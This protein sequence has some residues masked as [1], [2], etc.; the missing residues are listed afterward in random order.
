MK[1]ILLIGC[2]AVILFASCSKSPAVSPV[3]PPPVNKD[4]TVLATTT[5][6]LF[7]YTPN[8]NWINDP[9]GLVYFNGSYHLFSQYNPSGFV[10][11]NMN[12]DQAASTDFFS[13]QENGL[14]IKELFN[15][16]GSTAMIFSGST[17]V[18]SLN[19]SGFATQAGQIPLVAV[20]TLNNTAANGG[21][22]P[23]TQGIS[24]SLDNGQTWTAYSK[25]P[26]LDINSTQFRDPKV[27]WY[28]PSSKWI[29]VVSKPDVDSVRIYGST[30]LKKWTYQSDFGAIGNTNQV[31]ECPD[32]FPLTIEGGGAAKWVLTVSA[33]G[34]ENGFGGMQ[35]FIGTFDGT[36]FTADNYNYPLYVDF[37]KDYYAG[38]TFNGM[39]AADGRRVMVAW[40]N[41]WSYAGVIP[42]IGYRGQYSIPR[43]LSLRKVSNSDGY[44]L[45][46]SPVAELGA[47]ETT[48][49]TSASKNLS[50][51]VANLD[52]VSGTSLDIQF[53]LNMG[54]ATSA[55]INVLVS[56]TELTPVTINKTY[57][58]VSLDRTKSGNSS[59][60]GQFA[61]IESAKM[62]NV[63][64]GNITCRILI[65]QSIV[66]VFVN[67]GEYSITD[68]V[69]PT[70]AKGGIQLFSQG[71]AATFTNINVKT[72]SKTTH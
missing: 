5:R 39:P 41:N 46:Q 49:Y 71:G 53:T 15:T 40:A 56:G 52:S 68:L 21:A 54:T 30:N 33:G 42:T 26:V 19:T 2:L 69:F 25:N 61:G 28:A 51:T 43:S 31:W 36:K 67:G 48:L 4:T 20:Y 72:V 58:T 1:T 14:A 65:D 45:L 27:F 63:D 55:G 35:Y 18:D 13:W 32:M 62:N 22:L 24:Y 12:W 16:D 29:M 37:G 60:S 11:G 64:M 59:F 8:T 50:S 34:I 10:W 9:N 47:H 66:E 6:P 70:M 44:H 7:H 23:Q 38:V 3:T 57:S 17:V